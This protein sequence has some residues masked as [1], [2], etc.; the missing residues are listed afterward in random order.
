MSRGIPAL[1]RFI[2]GF[3]ENIPIGQDDRA[4]GDFFA[5]RAG[6]GQP[7]RCLH[8]G[9]VTGGGGTPTH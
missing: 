7:E 6:A 5:D 4:N 3:C 2:M 8:P 9:E 1:H